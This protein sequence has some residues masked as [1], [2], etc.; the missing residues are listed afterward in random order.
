MERDR[1]MGD[2]RG[3]VFDIQRYSIHDGQGI[4][5]TVFLKGCPLRCRWCANPE[6]WTS[7]PQLFFSEARCIK[8]GTCARFDGI[9]M[10]EPGPVIDRTK[11]KEIAEIAAACPSGALSVKGKLMTV[12]EVMAEAAKDIPFYNKSNGGV[13]LSGG[14]PLLQP[15][16]AAALLRACKEKG[17]HTIIETSGAAGWK[18]LK[19]VLPYTDQFFYDVKLAGSDLHERFTGMKNDTILSN[20]KRLKESGADVCVRVPVIPGVNDDKEELKNIVQVLKDLEVNRYEL[21]PF[22]QYGKGKYKSCGMEYEL[23]ELE[24]MPAEKFEILSSYFDEC[25]GIKHS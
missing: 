11:C 4:R 2:I 20:L 18:N 22:H 19:E 7:A 21:L 8:C 10:E 6:S 25:A 16:F 23:C 24:Q 1:I 14:E 9:V 5:T 17:L 12:S 3:N 13:T 15:E